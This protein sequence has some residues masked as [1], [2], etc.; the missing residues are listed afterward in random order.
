M[1]M[2][3]AVPTKKTY[4]AQYTWYVYMYTAGSMNIYGTHLMHI[5]Y[6]T[7]KT[8][9]CI[10]IITYRSRAIQ[11]IFPCIIHWTVTAFVMT[12]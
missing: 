5:F 4:L 6:G 12:A 2:F 11:Y 10:N 1:Q 7:I 9:L 3:T 8:K